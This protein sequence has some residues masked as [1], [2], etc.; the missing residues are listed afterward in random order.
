MRWNIKLHNKFLW[1][2]TKLRC[3]PAT[4]MWMT[5]IEFTNRELRI[6]SRAIYYSKRYLAFK[7]KQPE[8][9]GRNPLSSTSKYN[10]TSL[11]WRNQVEI[12]DMQDK[13]EA[14]EEAR[15]TEEE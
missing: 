3:T 2:V 12:L 8:R 6:F 5:H 9:K 15:E 14:E 7:H 4:S 11:N 10:L 13:E 1:E